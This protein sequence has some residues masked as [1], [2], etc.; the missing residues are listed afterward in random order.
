MRAYQHTVFYGVLLVLGLVCLLWSLPA[1]LFSRVLPRTA[2]AGFGQR[3][4]MAFFRLYVGLLQRTGYFQVDLTGL[5][6]LAR[7]GGLVIASN[8]P[9]LLDAML[10]ISR[11]PRVVCVMKAEI[12]DNPFLGGGAKL[13]GYI[14]NDTPLALI[15]RAAEAVRAGHQILIFPEGTRTVRP[16]VNGFK[17]GFAV[18]AKA[19]DAPIQ[20][21]LI[22]TGSPY[23]G[24]GW[25]ILRKPELPI[26][27]R[28]RLGRRF[29]VEGSAQAAVGE[30]E[31]YFREE[32]A[33]SPWQPL[34]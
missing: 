25:P 22:E 29:R 28:A 21:V 20:T 6:T 8:H 32:L 13:A 15:K 2:T 1:S 31:R 27:F 16:P 30:I 10:V 12:L 14:R 23:L 4:I 7:D 3:A 24:K 19:A 18:V 26:V 33:R 34:P 9:S 5:D 17:G 11:L